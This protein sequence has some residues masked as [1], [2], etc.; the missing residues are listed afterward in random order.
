MKKCLVIIFFSMIV[1][2]LSAQVVLMPGDYPDPTILKDGEDYY[3]T[4]TSNYY[5][6]GLLI[7]HSRD[8]LNW[9][10]IAKACADWKG[11]MR[12]PDIQKVGAC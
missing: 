1:S 7:W 6:P 2:S 3:M 8:L 9:T 4:H 12:V 11:A 10:P 5:K